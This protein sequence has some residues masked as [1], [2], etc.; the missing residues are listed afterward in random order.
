VLFR[1]ISAV[2]LLGLLTSTLP[3]QKPPSL[4]EEKP[5][6][7]P[8]NPAAFSGLKLRSIGPALTSGRIAALAVQ[9]KDH[10]TFYVAAASGGVWKTTNA[11]TTWTPI[12]D[13]EGSYSIGAITIDP[14]NP[15]ILWVGTGENNSQR[16]VSYGDGIYKSIDAGRSW[17][18]VGLGQ[19][20]HIARVII[21][22]RD[23]ETVYVAA[24]G[25]LWATGGDRGLYKTT[26][27]GKHWK[28]VLS[29]SDNTGVTDVVM[30]PRNPDVLIAASYQ[31]RRHVW[32]LINGG[33]ESALYKT[34]DG[35]KNW[36]KLKRGLPSVDLGRIGLAIA[37][38]DPDVV[39]ATIEAAENKGGIFRSTDGGENWQKQN[40]YNQQG[41]YYSTLSVDP[42]QKNRLYVMGT[43]L[44][45]SD[46]GGKTL[47]NLPQ[48]WMHVDHHAMWIDPNNTDH[49][50]VGCDGGL[51]E[52]L[53]RGRNWRFISNLPI[54]QFYDIAVDDN[55]PFYNI[56]GGTQDNFT[57]GG[58]TR[59]PSVH[60]I[61]NADWFVVQ[62]GDG[63][64]C[65]TDPKDPN[66]VYA[67]A[68]Y[69]ILVR[70]DR[71]TG[72]KVGIQ[73]QPGRGQPP[74]RWNWDSPLLISPHQHT[75]LYFAANKLFQSDDRGDSWKAISGDLTRQLNRNQ[76]P[77][78]GKVWG[79]EAVAKNLST[80]FYG[81]IV[82][83]AESPRKEGV[84]YAGTDDGLIQIT[85]DGGKNWRK[86]EKFPG[87]PDR[88][89]VSRVLASQHDPRTVYAAFDNHKMGDF[90]PYLLKSTD[91]GKTWESIAGDLPGRGQVRAIA[92]D[93]K[94]PDLL[95]AGTE[96]GLFF[97]VDGGKQWVRLKNGLPT[98][99]VK[100]LAIQKQMDDL[101]VGTFGR[102]FYILDDY[103]PLRGL[104]P[105]TLK[106]E[107][108]LFPI[109]DALQYIQTRQYGLPGKAFQGA[110]FFTADN[111]PFGAV[112]TYHLR[113]TIKT[114]KQK[115]IEAEKAAIKAGKKPTYPST[116][117]LRLEAEEEAPVI[118]LTVSDDA[119]KPLRTIT[120]PITQ[121][122]H[123]VVWD[124]RLPGPTLPRPR[125]RGERDEDLFAA[126][127]GGP[128]VLPG[129]YRVSLAKRVSGVSTPLKAEQTFKVVTWA[130]KAAEEP[131]QLAGR[132]Q[133]LDF[134]QKVGDLQKALNA[135]LSVA[136]DTTDRLSQIR[137]ALDH[138]PG[139]DPK[140]QKVVR[141][142]EKRNRDI[143]RALRGDEFLREHN[144]NAPESIQDRVGFILSS[145]RYTLSAPTGTQKQCY[146]IADA[147]L[148]EQVGKLRKL[149]EV[150]VKAVEKA[151]DAAGVPYTPGRLPR[152]K[153]K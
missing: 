7:G 99:A 51:Y 121:G 34:N 3:A 136:R 112:F 133:L 19:S 11:G 32:T 88:T 98:I 144:E 106:K 44:K 148:A 79:P 101:A 30:D 89:Y 129:T 72:Q 141:D 38:T 102:G 60:G 116:E 113:D 118:L 81:N 128:L 82:A 14:K 75:R 55:G 40:D 110:A 18:N 86:V 6:A 107:V 59:T 27:G 124:L 68:Q 62:G 8:L 84:L 25:P 2:L 69:G 13:N 31:R 12:F 126:P 9:P 78:M 85:E 23:S 97:T 135:A 20:E 109:R 63:F 26:D 119:G 49:Y 39:Y 142:L 70:F 105:G 1:Q 67:E 36:R 48:R 123:R 93:H 10:S 104:K 17:Q 53:D 57:L 139:L 58:P 28:K 43:F 111:P 66:I 91:A 33:P 50:R 37:P 120:G 96:F 29:I 125:P 56:Y 22:P 114:R 5:K 95:F 152:W 15:D 150:D 35:G 153:E 127:G 21:D 77:I 80:S 90:S 45:V 54:T 146:A 131:G 87:V 61:T 137:R 24:Q 47:S 140:W 73:P 64:Q 151:L 52:S 76:L 115:R 74:L 4:K 71:R 134:Q 83:L 122:T 132:K 149:V 42:G 103:T 65:R 145:Q 46:D 41:Q 130:P 138:T 147:E 117:E 108:A 92:E 94:D 143:L 100:D 16:S